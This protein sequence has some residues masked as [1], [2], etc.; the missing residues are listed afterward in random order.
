MSFCPNC[1]ITIRQVKA[2]ENASGS[3]RY[4]CKICR[5]KYTL[6]Q[7]PRLYSADYHEKAIQMYLAVMS[8]RAIARQMGVNHQTVINW[9]KN[10]SERSSR[11]MVH[12]YYRRLQD[13]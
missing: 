3:Q 9:I 6:Q 1:Q 2:G 12:S 13:L 10:Y 5:R 7:T 11:W 4:L 8:F